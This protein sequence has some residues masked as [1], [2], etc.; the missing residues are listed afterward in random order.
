MEK[1]YIYRVSNGNLVANE[2]IKDNA[3]SWLIQGPNHGYVLPK[4][5]GYSDIK[6]A[7]SKYKETLSDEIAA[8]E[9]KLTVCKNNLEKI[10]SD[11]NSIIVFNNIKSEE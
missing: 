2:L 1:I 11:P 5:N 3:N 7:I 9:S 8:L 4:K 6:E 10:D